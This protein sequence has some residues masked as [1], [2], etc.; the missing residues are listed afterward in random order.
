ME[1]KGKGMDRRELICIAIAIT[2]ALAA[3][4]YWLVLVS[5][6]YFTFRDGGQDL[7]VFAYNFYFNTH[8]PQIA[9]GLQFIALGDHLSPDS[10]AISLIYYLFPYAISLLYIQTIVV[11]L[12]SLLV[13]WVSR[14]LLNNSAVALAIS[15]AFL[16][17]PG[18]MGVL[19]FDFHLEFLIIPTYIL[20]FYAYMTSSKRLFAISFILLLGSLEVAVLPALTLGLGLMAYELSKSKYSWKAMEKGKRQMIIAMVLGSLMAGAMYY[21]CMVY[22]QAGYMTSYQQLPSMLKITTGSQFGLVSNIKSLFAS[23]VEFLSTNLSYFATPIGIYLLVLSVI[24][25]FFGFGFFTI[26]KP[27]VSLLL[28]LPWFVLVIVWSGNTHFIYTDYQYYSI[29]VGATIAAVIIGMMAVYQKM[30]DTR[31]RDVHLHMIQF[32]SII[33][34]ALIILSISLLTSPTPISYMNLQTPSYV[35]QTYSVMSQVPAN[36]SLMAEISVFPH[37]AKREQIEFTESAINFGYF[38]PDYILIDYHNSST[39]S[40]GGYDALNYSLTNYKYVLYSRDGNVYLYKLEGQ[41]SKQIS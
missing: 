14:R 5:H 41:E 33:M 39:L 7:S 12:T 8:Y 32:I 9:S 19:T 6:A 4:S 21:G 26:H 30:K 11:C 17:N 20:T 38:V 24:V 1:T 15:A 34:V 25:T 23:P 13:F 40:N 3:T 36:A 16:L 18:V 35:N 37:L 27:A 28:L 2:M 31:H 10:L 22:L 29:T